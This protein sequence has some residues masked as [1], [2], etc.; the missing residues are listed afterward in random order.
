VESPT[1]FF[2]A[3]FLAAAGAGLGGYVPIAVAIVNWFK[4]RRALPLGLASSGSAVGGLLTPVVVASLTVLGWRR[5]ALLSGVLILLIGLP[6]AQVF[7]HRPERYGEY[8]DGLPPGEG[9]PFG[10]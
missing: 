1:E 9:E 3:F 7:R 4:R 8:P 5:T 10:R 2:V 6:V